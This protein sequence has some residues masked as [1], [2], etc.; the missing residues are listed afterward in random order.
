MAFQ[1][2]NSRGVTYYLPLQRRQSQRRTEADDLL[3]RPRRPARRS[4]CGSR[5]LHGPGDDQDRD[6]HP[7]EEVSAFSFRTVSGDT[8]PR[9]ARG[10]ASKGNP[11]GGSPFFPLPGDSP[12]A[13]QA[14]DG[15]GPSEYTL[16]MNAP[17]LRILGAGLCLA[18]LLP[19]CGKK[20]SEASA[21]RANKRYQIAVIPKGR[22]MNSGRVSTPA[23]SGQ[24]A[25]STSK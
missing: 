6:A 15:L 20:P 3:L 22:P 12:S 24:P 13:V 1:F 14:F 9:Q 17:A 19:A 10:A 21:A 4:G 25:S 23:P 2:K 16:A 5:R 8:S 11:G 18:F 7:E